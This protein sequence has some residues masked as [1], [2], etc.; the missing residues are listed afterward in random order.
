MYDDVNGVESVLGCHGLIQ[1][2]RIFICRGRVLNAEFEGCEKVI[3]FGDR[4]FSERSSSSFT[5]KGLSSNN[6]G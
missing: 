4:M 5:A 1:D 3:K 2:G 6:K